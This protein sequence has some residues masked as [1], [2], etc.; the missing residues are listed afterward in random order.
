MIFFT[1]TTK[2]I[3]ESL[4]TRFARL[5]LATAFFQDLVIA[6]KVASLE[7]K[8]VKVWVSSTVDTATALGMN[9]AVFSLVMDVTEMRG[10]WI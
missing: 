2:N 3:S 6:L 9:L 7:I 5:F 4:L 1:F 10:I 8:E